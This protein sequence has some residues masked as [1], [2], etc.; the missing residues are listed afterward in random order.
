MKKRH[1]IVAYP[2]S[3]THTQTNERVHVRRLNGKRKGEKRRK[4]NVVPMRSVLS[5]F[6]GRNISL[7]MLITFYN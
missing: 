4:K 6:G 7:V 3:H 2:V 1:E 5:F